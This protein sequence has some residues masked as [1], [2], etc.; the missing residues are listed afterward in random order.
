MTLLLAA[1]LVAGQL[2]ARAAERARLLGLL[3]AV[4]ATRAQAGGTLLA[5]ALV[6]AIPGAALGVLLGE[7]LAR[8]VAFA[9]GQAAQADLSVTTRDPAGA[10][11]AFLLGVAASLVA[12]ALP[13]LRA[14]RAD[15]T[16]N[17][18]ARSRA[19]DP[20][21][22]ALAPAGAL[23][24]IAAALSLALDPADRADRAWTLARVLAALV[25]AA[26]LLPALV[27]AWVAVLR[28]LARDPTTA[29]GVSALRWR[30]V[31]SG[32]AAGAVLV[33]VAMAGGV[34]ALSRGLVRE[35]D[36]WSAR[37][38][39]WDLYAS[40][41][42]GFTD[43]E[44]A[45]VRGLPGVADATGISIRPVTVRFGDRPMPLALVAFDPDA[46]AR[47]DLLSVVTA[48]GAPAPDAAALVAS[49]SDDRG[50][51]VTTVLAEQLGVR[52]GDTVTLPGRRDVALTVRG[53]VVDYTQ[54]GFALL[55][56]Q[57]LLRASQ[58]ADRVDL[59][60]VRGDAR[61][62]LEALPGVVV[63]SRAELRGRILRLVAASM[64]AL[65][66]LLWL[67]G[68]VGVLAVSAALAQSAV[69]RRGDI[70]VLR[71]VGLERRQLPRLLV[72]EG[73][74]TAALGVTVGLPAGVLLG[75]V[76]ADAT[77]T[78]GIPIPY[79]PAWGPLLGASA[80]ALV[81]SALAAWLPA[82]RAAAVS[83]MEALR[84]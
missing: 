10:A 23:L 73:L 56:S 62:A 66:V 15:P 20:P 26:A 61:T 72:A 47:A 52:V 32:L 5:E 6:L 79:V 65:D 58:G 30:P 81:A 39:G 48:D 51:L 54:N 40:R 83:P 78:L 67:A 21:P 12:A 4:G 70:A 44:L 19:A 53:L 71:A 25:G 2:S 37:A 45:A 28:R 38:L 46:Y 77:H 29:L 3:R 59:V 1:L 60:A 69:E 34:G 80:A 27:P 41:P 14:A 13:A 36:E 63:E 33:C 8:G 50:A 57:S 16:T 22:R 82:R 31:R 74:A 17:L 24:L 11:R 49:L 76:F 84:E 9:L 18:R 35:M 42:D 75:K 7:P 68:A 43:A 55:V 64:A